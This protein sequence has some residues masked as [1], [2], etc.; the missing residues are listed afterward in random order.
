MIF[1]SLSYQLELLAVLVLI[2]NYFFI[3]LCNKMNFKHPGG[4]II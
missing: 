1:F 2:R 3:Y 4:S